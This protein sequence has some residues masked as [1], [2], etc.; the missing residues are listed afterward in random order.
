[1]FDE[2][3]HIDLDDLKSIGDFC[4]AYIGVTH[5]LGG[6]DFVYNGSGT[7]MSSS[8][9]E[10][11]RGE[12]IDI[13]STWDPMRSNDD[14]DLVCMA[15]S[16]YMRRCRHRVL[17]TFSSPRRGSRY[18]LLSLPVPWSRFVSSHCWSKTAT[19]YFSLGN[20]PIEVYGSVLQP[21]PAT[22][23]TA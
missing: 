20:G 7:G 10:A 14:E 4:T 18:P 17:N 9:G 21:R 13:S 23:S 15:L 8:K 3:P 16:S 22:S 5:C 1:M 2:Y 12:N 6:K 11:C 19:R